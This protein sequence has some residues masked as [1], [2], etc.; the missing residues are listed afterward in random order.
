VATLES[1]QKFLLDG[2]HNLS[3]A[4]SLAAALQTYFPGS[5]PVL[6]LG[7]LKDKDWTRMCQV[8][9]PLA[10]RV[11]LVP[12]HSE[13]SAEPHGL[14]EACHAANQQAAVVECASLADALAQ[15]EKAPFV[16]VAGSLYL[17]GEA[18][19]ML[20]LSTT[21]AIEERSLNEWSVR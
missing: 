7:I 1:G 8:L 21:K 20:H 3:G 9:A 4:Q 12:V 5:K 2:A 17:I 6:I 15:T 14:A 11:L 13:R 19:E 10:S 18:M 16:T